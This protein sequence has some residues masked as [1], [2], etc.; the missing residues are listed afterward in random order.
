MKSHRKKH[1][2]LTKET[3]RSL[4]LDRHAIEG[5][6]AKAWPITSQNVPCQTLLPV[7]CFPCGGGGVY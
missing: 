6:A 4:E 5:G 7:S 1:L 2:A 3:L